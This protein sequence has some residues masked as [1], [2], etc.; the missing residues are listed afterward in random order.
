MPRKKKPIWIQ[1]SFWMTE[2][3]GTPQSLFIHTIFFLS[4]GVVVLLGAPFDR[5]M[6]ILTTIVSLE[7]IYLSLFIQMTVNK[8]GKHI[9]DVRENIEDIQEDIED[10]QEETPIIP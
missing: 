5:V 9:K 4:C 8:Q 6:L 1:F 2:Q 10:L 7:A 3:V